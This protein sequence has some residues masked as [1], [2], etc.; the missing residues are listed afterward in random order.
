MRGGRE[1]GRGT[2]FW[3]CC[4]TRRTPKPADV[5]RKNPDSLTLGLVLLTYW[6]GLVRTVR[7]GQATRYPAM[8][9]DPKTPVQT[10][11]LLSGNKHLFASFLIRRPLLCPPQIYPFFATAPGKKTTATRSRRWLRT[12]YSPMPGKSRGSAR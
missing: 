4:P 6:R 11:Q 1:G 7:G 10:C 8:M 12:R 3:L 2:D 9:A 5:L